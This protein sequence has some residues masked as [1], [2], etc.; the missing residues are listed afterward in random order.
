MTRRLAALGL[1]GT[2]SYLGQG[3]AHWAD[4]LGQSGDWRSN[5]G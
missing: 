5:R 4:K 2:A 3:I 1:A